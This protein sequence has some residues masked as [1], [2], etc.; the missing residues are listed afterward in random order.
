MSSLPMGTTVEDSQERANETFDIRAS[1]AP[2][3]INEDEL[4]EAI[5][6]V[7]YSE[8][9]GYGNNLPQMVSSEKDGKVCH[10]ADNAGLEVVPTPLLGT[11]EPSGFRGWM[12]RRSRTVKL[13]ALAGLAILI[14]GI[15]IGTIF[16][17]RARTSSASSATAATSNGSAS[18]SPT[19]VGATAPSASP[20]ETTTQGKPYLVA[21]TVKTDQYIG[22]HYLYIFHQL[23]SSNEIRL[24][25]AAGEN[26]TWNGPREETIP[27]SF[28]AEAGTPLA[29]V[30]QPADDKA[31]GLFDL[32][33]LHVPV[34]SN[35][36]EIAHIRLNCDP[37]SG[38]SSFGS[39][40][41]TSP[42]DMYKVE[43]N[44]ATLAASLFRRNETGNR[45]MVL[46]YRTTSGGIAQKT[47]S[48]KSLTEDVTVTSVSKL[49]STDENFKL[50]TMAAA[51]MPEEEYVVFFGNEES[52]LQTW[53]NATSWFGPMAW[54]PENN[55]YWSRSL[56]LTACAHPR[57]FEYHA[58]YTD[59]RG[60]SIIEMHHTGNL[61]GHTYE[62]PIYTN[63]SRLQP[64]DGGRGGL[65][66]SCFDDSLVLVYWS[67]GKLVYGI[68]ANGTWTETMVL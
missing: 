18:G 51:G 33:Y 20:G 66:V 17:V 4:P 8:Y 26:F 61:L 56:T 57:K 68:K 7:A 54:K 65:A 67:Q 6:S 60:G 40:L 42:S 25:R 53:W 36:T 46:Y 5:P 55:S 47:L 35:S 28:Q 19:T 21:A 9:K 2:C 11:G 10:V 52:S 44:E 16:G 14:A 39:S 37:I 45:E 43:I 50:S 59:I 58:L 13:V 64:V 29:I 38:C 49:A 27:L 48:Y 32:F 12:A 31:N 34:A 41:V 1:T 63:L 22:G 3:T 23:A 30:G 62:E 24:N 15:V